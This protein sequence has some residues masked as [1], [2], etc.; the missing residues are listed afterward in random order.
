MVH[1]AAL[2]SQL[3]VSEP[4]FLGDTG[5][6][7]IEVYGPARDLLGRFRFKKRKIAIKVAEDMRFVLEKASDP[8][9]RN[10]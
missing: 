2:K 8:Q 3:I 4:Q 1:V 5:E 6:W 10:Q 7:M 9:T